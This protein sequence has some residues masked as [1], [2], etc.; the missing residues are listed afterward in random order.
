MMPHQALNDV[1]MQAT[2]SSTLVHSLYL[3][4]TRQGEQ[5]YSDFEKALGNCVL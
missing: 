4:L 5:E 3:L 2:V 1:Q